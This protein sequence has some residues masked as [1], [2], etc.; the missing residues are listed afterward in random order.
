MA[1]LARRDHAGRRGMLELR[2]EV[3]IANSNSSARDGG[4]SRRSGRLAR[5]ESVV[6][7]EILPRLIEVHAAAAAPALPVEI[8]AR[9]LL[10]GDDRAALAGFARLSATCGDD[11]R[12]LHDVLAPAARR[13]HDWWL[14]DSCDFFSVAQGVARLQALMA[15]LSAPVGYEAKGSRMLMCT[16]PGETH[17]FGA[18]MAADLFRREGWRVERADGDLKA[19]N[20]QCFD[21]V[22]VSCGCER[23]A[24][25][26]PQFIAKIKARA[27]SRV[28][29]LLGGALFLG[30]A[31]RGQNLGVDLIASDADSVMRFSRALLKPRRV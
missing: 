26:L 20:A 12:L 5:L 31:A 17:R 18:E 13:F 22:A 16:L 25:S 9:A 19:L 21:A 3:G 10:D 2:G 6:R 15:S 8:L 14:Q 24:A 29:I 1:T 27:C 4:K 28:P 11:L 30:H 23:A 7:K